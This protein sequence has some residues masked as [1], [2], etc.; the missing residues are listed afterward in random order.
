MKLPGPQDLIRCLSAN[1]VSTTI[2]RARLLLAIGIYCEM[3]LSK[4]V[5]VSTDHNYLVAKLGIS[6]RTAFEYCQVGRR[7][8]EF[9]YLSEVFCSGK[10]SYYKVRKLIRYLSQE[11]EH[12]LVDLAV[13]LT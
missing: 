4:C 10:L 8:L 13:S 11:N 2:Y 6:H 3:G 1:F 9:D 12:E 5:G 7:L